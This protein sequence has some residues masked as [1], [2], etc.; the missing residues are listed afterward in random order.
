MMTMNSSY[1]SIIFLLT[2]LSLSQSKFMPFKYCAKL[3]VF[4]LAGNDL[5]LWLSESGVNSSVQHNFRTLGLV[6]T[7]I[8][9]L[10]YYQL[11]STLG[12]SARD[13]LL[14]LLCAAQPHQNTT[15]GFNCESQLICSI[16]QQF[17]EPMRNS[18]AL[19][20]PICP[21]PRDS[22]N[23]Q[24]AQHLRA[25]SLVQASTPVT[26]IRNHDDDD[27]VEVEQ[28]VANLTIPYTV[29]DPAAL[30]ASRDWALPA[31]ALH[32][33]FGE[34]LSGQR[35][36]L[37][38]LLWLLRTHA[39]GRGLVEPVFVYNPRNA[40]LFEDLARHDPAALAAVGPADASGIVRFRG[41]PARLSHGVVA[42]PAGSLLDMRPLARYLGVSV[43]PY[44]AYV[45]QSR[46]SLTELLV[47]DPDLAGRQPV[48]A[49]PPPPPPAA[50]DGSGPRGPGAGKVEAELLGL[51][52]HIVRVRCWPDANGTALGGALASTGG[53]GAIG[54]VH[55]KGRLAAGPPAA[56]VSQWVA[57]LGYFRAR[58]A[59]R[60]RAAVLSHA[61]AYLRA[62]LGALPFLAA[63]W[64]RGDRLSI[65]A[66]LAAEPADVVDRVLAACAA[67]DLHRVHLMTNC[68]TAGDVA[69]VLAGLRAGGVEVAQV[70]GRVGRGWR[71]EP[72][73]VAVETA[74]AA[75]AEHVVVS[76]SA[77]SATVLE[78]RVLFGYGT[79]SWSHLTPGTEYNGNFEEL[80]LA[81]ERELETDAALG[82]A[83]R[84]QE[85]IG[86]RALECA[87]EGGPPLDVCVEILTRA[88]DAV[89]E[90]L[91]S[92]LPS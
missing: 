71:D 14:L 72:R 3:N 7:E 18:V 63:H 4:Q 57:G 47:V 75:L 89:S 87:Q 76:L 59:L 86:A 91:A 70:G 64:R 41:A 27:T 48:L 66:A 51:P 92:P 83:V 40:S 37:T 42:E 36:A 44:R 32:R 35:R 65:D 56:P 21:R 17:P 24:S 78:E 68:G 13:V 39:P 67:H 53:G 15:S 5:D 90:S 29:P 61:L 85:G 60:P 6:G 62:E 73:R 80:V 38:E 9:E 19:L 28:A 88:V 54:V 77:V 22:D 81:V 45:A 10:S 2:I 69:A 25:D 34:Q 33:F 74:A 26:P 23:I 84:E 52:W 49:C 20:F 58:A 8:F 46:A 12:L 43:L 82:S 55:A 79:R 1:K 16:A 30:H 50:E 31:A 11:T